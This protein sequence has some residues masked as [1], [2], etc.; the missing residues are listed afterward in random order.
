MHRAAK[1][2]IR[3]GC[4]DG[5]KRAKGRERYAICE[6]A[7]TTLNLNYLARLGY[8]SIKKDRLDPANVCIFTDT[9]FNLNLLPHFTIAYLTLQLRSKRDFRRETKVI[10][11]S[12]K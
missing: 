1:Q 4:D 2:C 5:K 8:T 12:N 10:C 11:R 9:C 7:P 3:N 6:L